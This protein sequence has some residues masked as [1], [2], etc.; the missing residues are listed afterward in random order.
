MS[1]SNI[2]KTWLKYCHVRKRLR[3][4]SAAVIAAL[5]VSAPVSAQDTE[6]KTGD[7]KDIIISAY[8]YH[9][10][11]KS[12][13]AELRGTREVLVDA[14]ANYLPQVVLDGSLNASSRDALLQD[15]TTFD[16]RNSPSSLN[17][18]MTQ[19]LYNGGRREMATRNAIYSVQS[20]E[21][22]YESI[23]T[24]IAAEI[25]QDYMSLLAAIAKDDALKTSVENFEDLERL[26][27]ARQAVGDSTRTE[28]SQTRSRLAQARAR[29]AAS[30][31]E[32]RN[33]RT[34]LL[35]KTGFLI[36][37]PT[38]PLE[39][40][41]PINQS[42]DVLKLMAR[43]ESAAL[44]SSKL[45]ALSARLNLRSESRKH[46]PTVTL[47]V[48]ASA[49]RNSSPTIDR[50]ND[51]NVGLRFTMPI[52]TAGVG[53]SQTRRAAANYNSAQ[54]SHENALRETDLRIAQ[55]WS[56]L[57]SGKFV[58]EAQE[59]AVAATDDALIGV[60]R[61]EEV[62]LT[63]TQ[64]ILDAAQNK[65]NA[66]IALADAQYQHYTTRLLLKL[67]IG[68]FDVYDFD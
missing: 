66:D 2:P 33:A 13:R 65:L 18:R 15:G 39:A 46:L 47:T 7:L 8:A 4:T 5:C 38:L 50:D 14:R 16:Q 67:Y 45:N 17:L 11:L 27:L 49:V 42:L 3:Q 40:K 52:Y 35:S 59:S 41:A 43:E 29:R 64:D 20:S 32:L 56:Q 23:A 60:T 10:Q 25:I 19:T 48:N 63:S 36:E 34:R 62:G 37:K 6:H 68:Q 1:Q 31:A 58:I 26:M 53:R 51:L 24:S 54:F 22:R 12:L 9:P 61:G 44:E 21:A 57:Q 55:F 28:V 30:L